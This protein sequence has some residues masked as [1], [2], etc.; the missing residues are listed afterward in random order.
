MSSQLVAF[1]GSG[2]RSPTAKLGGQKTSQD[3]VPIGSAEDLC[4]Q[5]AV[6]GWAGLQFRW[7]VF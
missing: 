1:T 3:I 5:S 7:P 4:A 6:S 2:I